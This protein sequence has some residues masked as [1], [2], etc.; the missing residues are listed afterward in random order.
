VQ[1]IGDAGFS[2]RRSR[3]HHPQWESMHTNLSNDLTARLR[4]GG[5]RVRFLT[6]A[7]SEGSWSSPVGHRARRHPAGRA[8][9]AIIG[10]EAGRL[11]DWAA[12]VGQRVRLQPPPSATETQARFPPGAAQPGI[13][14]SSTA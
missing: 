12:D 7:A 14:G 1:T 9:R 8:D 3:G 10:P 11:D 4:S 13:A 6:R 5:S 2:W